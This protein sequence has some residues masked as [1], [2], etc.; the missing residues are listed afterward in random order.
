MANPG[1]QL[2]VRATP[3]PTHTPIQMAGQLNPCIAP[4]KDLF[5]LLAVKRRHST[6]PQELCKKKD[7]E[8]KRE[9]LSAAR[10]ASRVGFLTWPPI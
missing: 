10:G 2:N 8:T 7:V 9:L 6:E 5:G 3:S 4:A 1:Q